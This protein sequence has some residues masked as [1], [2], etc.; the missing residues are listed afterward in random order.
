MILTF[1][2]FYRTP[3]KERSPKK[4]VQRQMSLQSEAPNSFNSQS[5]LR[6]SRKAPSVLS[7]FQRVFTR[8]NSKYSSCPLLIASMLMPKMFLSLL[9]KK[10]WVAIYPSHLHVNQ[11][12]IVAP[13]DTVQAE[14]VDHILR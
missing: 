2:Y 4:K 13:A 8:D 10:Q 1:T 14:S 9:G 12:L 7:V 6:L 3:V 11:D 5:R